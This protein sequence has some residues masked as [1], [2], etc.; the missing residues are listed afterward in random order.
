MAQVTVTAQYIA[1]TTAYVRNVKRSIEVTEELSKS[2]PKVEQAQ[3]KV[4]TSSIALG[5]ALGTLGALAFQRATGAVMRFAQQGIRAAKDYEQT[6]ISIEGI[7]AGTGMSMQEAAEKTQSYLAEL[8]DFAAK[9]PFEL[10]QTLD[11]V[12]RLLSIGYAADDVKDRLLPA[13]GDI[14]S[15]LGQPASSISAVV[16]AFGQMKSAGRVLSQDLMQIGN[17]LPGFNA[18]MAL[19]NELFQGDFGALTKAMESGSLD[20]SKAIDVLITAMTKFGGAAG[21]MERQSG[22]LAGVMST[23]ADTVN[24]ALIDGLLPSLPELS[25]TLNDIMPAVQG[26]ATAFA[27]AL[28]PA[29][30]DGA[31]VLGDLAPTLATAIPPLIEM[32]SRLTVMADVLVALAP[33]LDFVANTVGLFADVLAKVPAPLAAA[34]GGVLLLRIAM[35]KLQIDTSMAATGFGAAI[36]RIQTSLRALVMGVQLASSQVTGALAKIVIS[37]RTMSVAFVGGLRT[38]GVA[39]RGFMAALGPVGLAIAGISAAF[40]IFGGKSAAAQGLIDTLTA[41]L[42]EVTKGFGDAASAAV[43]AQFRLDLSPEDQLILAGLGIGVDK[44]T[45]AVVAG[46]PEM[47]AFRL[48]LRAMADDAETF[49][50]DLGEYSSLLDTY[51]RNFEGMGDAASHVR[52]QVEATRIEQ[53]NAA[54]AAYSAA[55]AYSNLEKET[56]STADA[57]KGYASTQAAAN[58]G[59]RDL[60]IS[61]MG[62]AYTTQ[63]VTDAATANYLKTQS[64]TY[65]QQRLEEAYKGVNAALDKLN[66]VLTNEA[67]F[68][69]AVAS[70]QALN[71]ELKKNTDYSKNNTKEQREGRAAIRESIQG[72][73]DY[74]NQADT[75]SERNKRLTEG[76]KAVKQEL[77]KKGIKGKDLDVVAAFDEA[78]TESNKLTSAFERQAAVA[79]QFGNESG[80]NFIQ[81]ILKELREGKAEVYLES[82]SVGN[83]MPAG[84]DAGTAS[85][86]PSRKGMQNAKNFID[87]IIAGVKANR[88]AAEKEISDLGQAI[89]DRLGERFSEFTQLVDQAGSAIASIRSATRQ[90]FGEPSDIMRAFGSDGDVSSAIN[91]YDQLSEAIKD[92]YAPLLDAEVVGAKVA[93]DARRSMREDLN[94]L[95]DNTAATIDAMRRRE[96]ALTQM[97]QVQ[98]KTADKID[99]INARYDTLDKAAS[100]SIDSIQSRW[101][102]IIPGLE[103]TLRD[104]NDA[105]DRENRVLENLINERD[106]F[107]SR[108]GSGLR[109]F[110]NDLGNVAK[111][112]V[113]VTEQLASGLTITTQSEVSDASSFRD[114]LEARLAAIRAFTSNI[115]NLLA[116]GLDPSLVQDFVS[117]GV[118]SAGD[119]VAALAGAADSEIAAINTAQASLNSE[120]SAF[121]QAASAQWYDAG[122]AQQEAV[123]APLRSAAA[124]AQA[125]LDLAKSTR[126]TELAAAQK[127]ADDL[128]VLRQD[129]IRKAEADRDAELLRLQ[130]IVDAIQNTELPARAAAIQAIFTALQTSLPAETKKV[131]KEAINGI[132]AGLKAREDALYGKAREIANNVAETLRSAFAVRSPSRVTKTIGQQVAEG[133]IEGMRSSERSVARAAVSLADQVTAP[134]AAPTFSG[135]SAAPATGFATMGGYGPSVVHNKFEVNVQSLAGDKRQIGR[136]VVEAIKAFERS[137]GPV[138]Q[139]ASV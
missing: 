97:S 98:Q 135:V 18:K 22:T 64:L 54:R 109:D 40:E 73:V 36:I 21:A 94:A 55:D 118:G 39:I 12:K 16:Y 44:A 129:E 50:S 89:V 7:F 79:Q 116:R 56:W 47:E 48:K 61:A 17:A 124:A 58:S 63:Q 13:I 52:A 74:A 37:A 122:I 100:D 128:R 60:T 96:A 10:P 75:A 102:G 66:A 5:A 69:S 19:A 31:M 2:L 24:N 99:E 76:Y 107:L 120:I 45:A 130:G 80:S 134:I 101:D 85:S 91:M 84:V 92:A 125:A 25:K 9:T 123:V 121:Q 90:P 106:N 108:I 70:T 30:I 138:Y 51:G 105:F 34:V 88:A 53:E 57:Y 23:F 27:Q 38:M 65:A 71:K 81:G 93:R 43:E 137:S 103:K 41:S 127:H 1:D 59:M 131:G 29:L 86:S 68:D 14:V 78:K 4:K 112:T 67:A 28:G 62:V 114:N 132:I 6:V 115:R 136:E 95:E 117:A 46:G 26:V 42:D 104:A 33:F 111:K 8:R 11:A 35:K 77:K 119:T 3:D 15:A 83:M 49:G 32:S 110:A 20:S 139:P 72:W 87:G 133:L 126:E 113:T 82:V